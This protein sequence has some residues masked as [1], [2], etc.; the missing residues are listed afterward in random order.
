MKNILN[1][2]TYRQSKNHKIVCFTFYV[3]KLRQYHNI[4][5]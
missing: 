3:K 2:D 4:L 5:L 1:I